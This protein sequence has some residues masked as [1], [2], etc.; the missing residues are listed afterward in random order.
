MV[1]SKL[2]AAHSLRPICTFSLAIKHCFFLVDEGTTILGNVANQSRD[3][4]AL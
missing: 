4:T 2:R 3:D 1:N